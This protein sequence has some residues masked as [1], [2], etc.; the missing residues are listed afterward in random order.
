M[1]NFMPDSAL[2]I[3]FCGRYRLEKQ[4]DP[5]KMH[6]LYIDKLFAASE[7]TVAVPPVFPGLR[8][9]FQASKAA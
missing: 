1:V 3:F 7:N 9:A 6:C 5:R 4:A 8:S 2:R